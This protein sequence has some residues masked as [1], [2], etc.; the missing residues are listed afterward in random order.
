MNREGSGPV[1]VRSRSDLTPGIAISLILLCLA[2][3]EGRE[4]TEVTLAQLVAQQTHYADRLVLVEGR[5][6]SHP[7]PLHYWIEDNDHHR[8]ELSSPGGLTGLEGK[9]LA[10]RG[11]FRYDDG[12]GRSIDV[13][14]LRPLGSGPNGT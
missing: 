10:V 1:G 7:D 14:S 12:R 8:V 5:L 2:A 9:R 4:A 6:R 3:C 13:D 11:R